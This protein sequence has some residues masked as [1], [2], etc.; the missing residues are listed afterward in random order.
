MLN[1]QGFRK[2][3]VNATGPDNLYL[4]PDALAPQNN[5]GFLVE[6]ARRLPHVNFAD[7]A[8]GR[9]Y[10]RLFAG[11]PV[12]ADAAALR[13]AMA[14]PGTRI[15]LLAVA[16]NLDTAPIPEPDQPV[17]LGSHL[18]VERIHTLGRWGVSP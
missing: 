14:D 15:G 7:Q 11:K 5:T 3:N 18:G 8:T 10:L 17:Y 2:V 4:D 13:A 6:C 16:P 1:M 12:W 9:V